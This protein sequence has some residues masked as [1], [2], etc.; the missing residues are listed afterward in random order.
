M[1]E[2]LSAEILVRLSEGR[3][4]DDLGI[5]KR[6]GRLDIRGLRSA[7]RPDAH[8]YHLP[9]ADVRVLTDT[10]ILRGR[11]LRSLDFTGSKIENLRIFDCDIE[12]CIFDEC[13]FKDLRTWSSRFRDCSFQRAKLG[14][15]VLGGVENGVV[16]KYRNVD[17]SGAD[18]K[19]SS[20]TAAVFEECCFRNAH[21]VAIDFQSSVFI[22]C[23]FVGELRDVSFHRHGSQGEHFPPN[24]MKDVDLSQAR[25]RNVEFRR[26]DMR[27]ARL[28]VDGDHLIMHDAASSLDNVI[29]AM[30]KS[31]DLASRQLHAYFSVY[32]KWLPSGKVQGVISLLDIQ[33]IGGE[34]AVQRIQEL[35]GSQT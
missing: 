32:R 27:Q 7:A 13:N 29:D 19:K 16:P 20:Y 8:R 33:E 10:L 17:F 1:N 12:D 25:F 34:S 30:A 11:S 26:I 5:G 24:E 4:L 2:Q 28:P 14:R 3:S 18:M 22:K 35:I 21:L 9:F 6:D 23:L 15:A 31:S